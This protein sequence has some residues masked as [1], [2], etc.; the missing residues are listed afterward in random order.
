MTKIIPK[1]CADCTEMDKLS[2]TNVIKYLGLGG[3][4]EIIERLFWLFDKDN[5][6]DVDYKEFILGLGV[7]N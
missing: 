3:S 1:S 4:N 6:G 5:S 2:F 7:F